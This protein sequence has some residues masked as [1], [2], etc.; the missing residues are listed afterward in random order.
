MQEVRE[1]SLLTDAL[2]NCSMFD[3]RNESETVYIP[4]SQ[5]RFI[6]SDLITCELNFRINRITMFYYAALYLTFTPSLKSH[7][8]IQRRKVK[9]QKQGLQIIMQ[10]HKHSVCFKSY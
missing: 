10:F 8:V 6:K 5:P 2:S 4:I 1:N 9:P 7:R 3:L